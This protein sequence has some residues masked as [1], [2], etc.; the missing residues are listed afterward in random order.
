MFKR[1]FIFLFILILGNS[2]S[3]FALDFNCSNSEC[4][5]EF[6][7]VKSSKYFSGAIIKGDFEKTPTYV[8]FKFANGTLSDWIFLYHHVDSKYEHDHHNH[9]SGKH[10]HDGFA[11]IHNGFNK[12]SDGPEYKYDT[13]ADGEIFIHT[14][15][16]TALR[17][18]SEKAIDNLDFELIGLMDEIPKNLMA[19]SDFSGLNIISRNSWGGFEK[20]NNRLKLVASRSFL[21]DFSQFYSKED[22]EISQVL[23]FVDNKALLWPR[24]YAKEIKMLV[25]HHTASTNEI[26]NP[27]QAIKNIHQYHANIKNWGDI[28]YHYVIAPDGKIFEGRAGGAGVVGGHSYDVNKVSVGISVMGNYQT[29]QVPTAVM[30]SL[31]GLL[32]KLTEQYDLDPNGVVRYKDQKIPVIAGH[33]D[34]G[35]TLCPGVYL[36][37]RIPELRS[38]VSSNLSMNP[39]PFALD[40]DNLFNVEPLV[41]N[42]IKVKLENLTTQRWQ[43]TST[44]LIA[45]NLE[46]K[47]LVENKSFSL[48]TNNVAPG[49]SGNFE[50]KFKPQSLS[51]FKTL[52]FKLQHNGVTFDQELFVNI[53]IKQFDIDYAFDAG[54][55]KVNTKQGK[56]TNVE[57]KLT[58]NSEID[59]NSKN[60]VYLAILNTDSAEDLVSI[61]SNKIN[62]S[63]GK[64]KKFKVSV[65]GAKKSGIY[66]FK[67]GLVSP[68]I[69]VIDG[70]ELDLIVYNSSSS[71][72]R[73]KK[74]KYLYSYSLPV[75]K[76]QKVTVS[77]PNNTNRTW[78][79]E[80]F[81]ITSLTDY[82]TFITIPKM[83]QSSVRPGQSATVKFSARVDNQNPHVILMRF[84]NEKFVYSKFTRV[85]IN[86]NQK[87]TITKEPVRN[88]ALDSSVRSVS[89]VTSRPTIATPA[90]VL[91]PAPVASVDSRNEKNPLLRVHITQA[92]LD[93]YEITCNT[94]FISNLG[95]LRQYKASEVINV[96]IKSANQQIAR[97]EPIK[98]GVCTV[99]NLE[100]RPAWNKNLNDNSFRGNLEL[101]F[102]NNQ[103]ILINEIRMEDYL[104]GL[105][106][107]SNSSHIEK[108]KTIMV[109]ARSYAYYYALVDRKFPGKPYDLNDD[110]NATQ[111]YIGYG[112]QK[113]SP[114]VS[115]AVTATYGKVIGYNGNVIKV[116]YFNQS[117]G[118]TKSA[119]DVWG[120][121]NVPYLKGVSDPYCKQTRF[122]GHGVGISGCGASQMAL[123][124]FSY[125]K[126][127][128]YYL[129][130]T[131][132]KTIY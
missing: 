96:N 47:K 131:E 78:T 112:M 58:N 8:Q 44:K 71:K 35:K 102:D 52:R 82:N 75:N 4:L 97:F 83:T 54:S 128:K 124:G 68:E 3:V 90:P 110:P 69:G 5:S 36:Y 109:A 12:K 67:L 94:P 10:E 62:L 115:K 76:W 119:L 118:Y 30:H 1:F 126:I 31:A 48:K 130:G 103:A 108:A 26:D 40:S 129:P 53:V 43:S 122:L 92:N 98:D 9:H 42:T 85:E 116:P 117:A 66:T 93:K 72:L 59:F 7:T 17:F 2:G 55:L 41:E 99:L 39:K 28:G 37:E 34:T 32:E 60:P 6:E 107:V 101:R 65:D 114:L 20:A 73:G 120:W 64:S 127:I 38:W 18:K 27:M 49:R 11:H 57:F 70:N 15:T 87:P 88:A 23:G 56:S 89:Q 84:F 79:Q 121:K 29:N 111:K 50:L 63:A 81:K 106:E 123:E 51:G 125:D 24:K 19:G 132:I 61:R 21:P 16:A 45:A 80:N 74:M 104:K 86:Y 25:I 105:G 95:G 100:R 113:R 77:V 14:K 22:P 91:A 46:T 13:H 33:M